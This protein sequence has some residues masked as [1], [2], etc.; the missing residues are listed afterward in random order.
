MEKIPEQETVARNPQNHS[1]FL[2]SIVA[3]IS[4]DT[5]IKR[6]LGQ[7]HHGLFDASIE[8]GC[9]QEEIEW[10]RETFLALD[11]VCKKGSETWTDSAE[12]VLAMALHPIFTLA[13]SMELAPQVSENNMAV[14]R[15]CMHLMRAGGPSH[16]MTARHLRTMELNIRR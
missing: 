3:S 1:P 2:D 11:M 10:C 8:W 16:E 9:L 15:Q 4:S 13:E 7:K 6:H 12:Q 5:S 14:V